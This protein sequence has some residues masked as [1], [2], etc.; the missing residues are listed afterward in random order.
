MV[1]ALILCFTACARSESSDEVETTPSECFNYEHVAQV[2]ISE[3]GYQVAMEFLNQMPILF[4]DLFIPIT[5]RG[6]RWEQGFELEEGQFLKWRMV[7]N[8]WQEIITYEVPDLF[9]RRDRDLEGNTTENHGFFDG[10]GNRII[11][12]PWVWG[13]FY[14]TSFRL[15]DFDNNGIPTI[16]LYF[17]GNWYNMTSNRGTPGRIFRYVDG[18]Y[19]LFEEVRDAVNWWHSIH[20]YW[21]QFYF[22]SDNNLVRSDAGLGGGY[23]IW[24]DYVTFINNE[25]HFTRIARYEITHPI[26]WENHITGESGLFM[27]EDVQHIM[28]NTHLLPFYSMN[29]QLTPIQSINVFLD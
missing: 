25:T 15:W 20:S 28:T 4:M 10:Q 11:D 21:S 22:C 19:Q 17:E 24:F 8:E 29:I 9:F 18:E 1:F 5:G 26:E 13:D 7:E 27:E 14:A 23:F 2:Q 6:E 16:T 12:V 3:Y